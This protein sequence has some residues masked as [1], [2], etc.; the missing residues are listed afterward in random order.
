M[1]IAIVTN[2][3]AG[4]GLT[5][6]FEL[7][8]DYLV[9]LGHEPTGFQYD[10]KPDESVERFDL[11]IYLETIPQEWLFLS[12]RRWWFPNPE[13]CRPEVIQTAQ[14]NC[15]A[16]FAKTHYAKE[17]F[18][19][20]FP[21]KVHYT[22]FLTTD[23]YDPTVKR[24]PWF[25]HIGGNSSIRGT[26]AV[27]DA[28][29]WAKDGKKIDAKLCV[30]SNVQENWPKQDNIFYW[31]RL[32]EADLKTLQNQCMFHIYPSQTEGFGHAIH[33]GQ[34][35][36]ATVLVTHGGALEE[37]DE[38]VGLEATKCGKFNL[39]DLYEV[40]ALTIYE[41]VQE[42]LEKNPTDLLPIEGGGWESNLHPRDYF[43]NGNEEFKE[44]FKEQLDAPAPTYAIRRIRKAG[45]PK[46][47]AFLGNFEASEST[48]NQ[49]LWALEQRLGYEVEKLQENHVTLHQLEEAVD[50]NDIF[51]WVHT[52]GFLKVS[53][54]KMSGL[55]EKMRRIG[56]PSY[57]LH[58]DKYLGIPEREAVVGKHSFWLTDQVWTA[59]GSNPEW[60]EKKG[61]HHF[62]MRPAVSEVYC[63]PGTPREQYKCDVMFCGAKGYHREYGYRPLMIDFLERQYGERFK[64]VEGV[65]GHE[66]NDAY[67]SARVIVG[68]HIF[69]G[70]PRY[71][72]D[73]AMETVGRHGFLLYPK[74]DGLCI[75]CATYEPQNLDDLKV[76]IEYWLSNENT[77][78]DTLRVSAEHVR[79]HDTWTIRLAEILC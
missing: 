66:L 1:R 52:R 33:E 38:C 11:A 27:L 20:L 23:K 70:I 64:H 56:M 34:S 75:P 67:S 78:C 21:G 12:D 6:D 43:L 53:D 15:Q 19:K 71:F 32:P 47:I 7:L 74:T 5:K 54:S 2:I 8:R 58:L 25:L 45:D 13:W 31:K 68:D 63:H 44:V 50:W 22:G 41:M 37:L 26:Q 29:Q 49:M 42:V 72:S 76:Q 9:E 55:V 51:I 65:R 79:L 57:S 39:A 4:I 17:L 28:W 3:T 77:R 61:V 59:D 24:E 73:R 10:D 14:R 48:E 30:V 62:W 60:F 40:S 46:R 18:D 69:S 36:G 35:V 16:V